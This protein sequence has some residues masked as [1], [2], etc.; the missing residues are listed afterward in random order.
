MSNMDL[1]SAK[2]LSNKDILIDIYSVVKQAAIDTTTDPSVISQKNNVCLLPM[3]VEGIKRTQSKERCIDSKDASVQY[4]PDALTV[5]GG[6][7]LNF[8]DFELQEFKV[9][10]GI[11]EL[12][13]FIKKSTADLD[14]VWWPL[15]SISNQSLYNKLAISQSIAIETIARIFTN[16]L[17]ERFNAL[18]D[19]DL[20]TSISNILGGKVTVSVTIRPTYPAGV[21]NIECTFIANNI[22]YKIIEIAI[23]DTASGQRYDK[24]GIEINQLLPMTMD[25]VYTTL[26]ANTPSTITQLDFEKEKVSVC[27]IIQFTK[28]QL[29]AFNLLTKAKLVKSL[30]NYKRIVYIIELL[31]NIQT[32]NSR[33]IEILKSV[34]G[35]NSYQERTNILQYIMDEVYSSIKLNYLN[36]IDI[37]KSVEVRDPIINELLSI[38]LYD[39]L[40]DLSYKYENKRLNI[41]APLRKFKRTRKPIPQNVKNNVQTKINSLDRE[42]EAA[43][44]DI[45]SILDKIKN[46]TSSLLKIKNTTKTNTISQQ[47]HQQEQ[48]KQQ[49]P[50]HIAMLPPPTVPVTAQQ[51]TILPQS[52]TP[53]SSNITQLSNYK[54]IRPTAPPISPTPI[55]QSYSIKP[56]VQYPQQ[57][58][59]QQQYQLQPQY[60]YQS[61]PKY[62]YTRKQPRV[63]VPPPPILMPP[64]SQSTIPVVPKASY[65]PDLEY[66]RSLPP[67]LA[68]Q[69]KQKQ[70]VA[71]LGSRLSYNKQTNTYTV[72]DVLHNMWMNVQYNSKENKYYT[73]DP[74]M[75][76]FNPLYYNVAT[77][78]YYPV[79][80]YPKIQQYAIYDDISGMKINVYY[81]N[82]TKQFEMRN[83]EVF[84]SIGKHYYGGKKTKKNKTI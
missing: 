80:Y 57:Q 69:Q 29:F 26:Q 55:N 75:K 41:E 72:F 52:Y 15:Y 61:T 66:T 21:W 19:S 81:N 14:M 22:N 74:F 59:P 63:S 79:Y 16:K 25:P 6:A 3:Q 67:P 76:Q 12:Q 54:Y 56:V 5:I 34:F 82:D 10:K 39:Q 68:E 13:E 30:T 36:I 33:N 47:Q 7:A 35:I 28:Q 70:S 45:G 43:K 53:P 64:V 40:K 84:K 37:C 65:R 42:H 18:E 62:N 73:Y 44:S 1:L 71:S 50:Q 20:M 83:Q 51:V 31:N 27:N 4:Y 11:P 2:I 78:I 38:A 49:L 77:G 58:Y 23:H 60:L 24:Y 32:D 17:I 46:S 9:R 48:Q 8:Y